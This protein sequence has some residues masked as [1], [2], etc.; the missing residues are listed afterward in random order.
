MADEKDTPEDPSA[1]EPAKK[2]GLLVREHFYPYPLGRCV[3]GTKESLENLSPDEARGFYY[4]VTYTLTE[5]PEDRAY[6]H[7]QWR[8]SNPLPYQV[9]HTILDGVEGQGH[10]VGTYL[11]W[12]VNN[13][14]E[15]KQRPDNQFAWRR[16]VVK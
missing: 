5:V 3:Q 9:P 11:A 8:R 13:K 14:V 16:V 2:S 1:N 6:F 7:A 12:G 15:R 10:F 4:Q